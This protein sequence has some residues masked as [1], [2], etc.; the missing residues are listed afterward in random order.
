MAKVCERCGT[1]YRLRTISENKGKHLCRDC[2]SHC[3]VCGKKL[4]RSNYFGETASITGAFL[5]PVAGSLRDSRRPHIGSG[6]CIE[7]FYKEHERLK[8]K[9]ERMKDDDAYKVLKLRYGK[10][11]ISKKEYEE[12][13]KVLD[14]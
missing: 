1:K 10:G 6:M 11:E 12:M 13:K 4:P 5:G 3:S 8:K 2:V 7:C 9:V 14:D